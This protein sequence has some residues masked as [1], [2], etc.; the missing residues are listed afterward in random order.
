MVALRR[1]LTVIGV[2][3]VAIGLLWMAQGAGIFPY[4]SSSFMIN[5]TPWILRGGL[6]AGFGLLLTWG[7]GR[8]IR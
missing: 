6:L 4:P 2:V 5:Q 7:S 1:I 8:L 3:A